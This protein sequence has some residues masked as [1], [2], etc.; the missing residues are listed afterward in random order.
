AAS[1]AAAA[2]QVRSGRLG[3]GGGKGKSDGDDCGDE[4]LVPLL[5]LVE[6]LAQDALFSPISNRDVVM[7]QQA[8]AA[9]FPTAARV[10]PVFSN[11]ANVYGLLHHSSGDETDASDGSGGKGKDT[12]G[13]GERE[14][15]PFEG[16]LLVFRRGNGVEETTGRL[17]LK[18]LDYVQSNA[19]G[20]LSQSVTDTFKGWQEQLVALVDSFARDVDRRREGIV[21]SC[22]EGVVAFGV[23][24]D[25]LA[26]FVA[27]AN[28]TEIA[29]REREAVE[30]AMEALRRNAR[31]GP[32]NLQR[33][34]MRQVNVKLEEFSEGGAWPPGGD[35]WFWDS[36][37]E[38]ET[39]ERGVQLGGISDAGSEGG[40][41]VT[42]GNK[43]SSAVLP[44]VTLASVLSPRPSF[45]KEGQGSTGSSKNGR[46]SGADSDSES[47]SVLSRLLSKCT[48]KEPTYD[49][50]NIP[51]MRR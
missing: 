6:D 27:V 47:K 42:P 38:A 35:S 17:L 40:E 26:R 18:K 39:G 20:W 12:G 28:E 21:R 22:V 46:W 50:V 23:E 31:R 24:R 10:R 43:V 3:G 16:R 4:E 13:G 36:R 2:G 37:V 32:V 33:Y 44:R 29:S 30:E 8:L 14:Q 48:V 34:G 5:Q 11:L 15:V 7:S 25:T 9:E 19:V 41:S 51:G 1:A 49:E 45:P